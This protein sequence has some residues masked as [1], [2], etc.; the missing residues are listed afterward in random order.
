MDKK[1]MDI[2]DSYLEQLDACIST[3]VVVLGQYS[4]PVLATI[5]K[6]NRY[7]QVIPVGE[8]NTNPILDSCIYE[9]EYP[10]GRIEEYSVNSIL[11]NLLKQPDKD[12]LELA[13]IE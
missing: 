4:A 10:E 13:Y 6:I 7:S 1:T 2:Y 3:K 5:V 12:G 8:A 9:L 11:E